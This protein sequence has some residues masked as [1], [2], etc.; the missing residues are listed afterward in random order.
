MVNKVCLGFWSLNLIYQFLTITYLILLCG[1]VE[2]NP[3]P[4]LLNLQTFDGYKKRK[5]NANLHPCFV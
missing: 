2:S 4:N 3:G 1:D 5:A